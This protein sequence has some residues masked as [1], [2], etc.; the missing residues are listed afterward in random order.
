MK[1]QENTSKNID[2]IPKMNYFS[3]N[4][5]NTAELAKWTLEY[6]ESTDYRDVVVEMIIDESTSKT[7]ILPDMYAVKYMESVT[8]SNGNS[9]Y[10]ILL[11]QKRYSNRKIQIK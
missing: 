10:E 5:K 3:S 7:C 6:G 8:V 2:I 11:K 9:I 4:F 1:S